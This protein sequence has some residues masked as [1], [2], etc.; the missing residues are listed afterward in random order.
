MIGKKTSNSWCMA[1]I[2]IKVVSDINQDC[3]SLRVDDIIALVT[4]TFGFAKNTC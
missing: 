1:M 4:S 3:V 2:L